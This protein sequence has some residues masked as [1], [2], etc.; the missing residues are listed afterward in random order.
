ML[1]G[2]LVP[3]GWRLCYSASFTYH[4][5][6]VPKR[7]CKRKPMF[8]VWSCRT[9]HSKGA[10]NQGKEKPG[11]LERMSRCPQEIMVETWPADAGCSKE[12]A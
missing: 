4:T 11:N 5:G 12:V 1:F 2:L 10:E 7:V 6:W 8:L 9:N 3:T